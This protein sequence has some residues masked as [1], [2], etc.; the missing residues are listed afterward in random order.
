MEF[1]RLEHWSGWPFPSPE[2]LPDPEIEPG[3]PA[4]QAD[5]S[6]AELS[7]KL[8]Y[9]EFRKMVLVS[10]RAGKEWRGRCREQ[11]CGHS[12]G[13][14]GQMETG[15][16]RPSRVRQTT[17]GKVLCGPGLGPAPCHDSRAGARGRYICIYLI[18][19]DPHCCMAETNK[20]L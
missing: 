12:G 15:A 19:T 1:S 10:L 6:P 13:R 4:L 2:D 7:G 11:V 20:T 9:K 8:M 18:M 3:S 17:S 16:Y 5:P 14:R